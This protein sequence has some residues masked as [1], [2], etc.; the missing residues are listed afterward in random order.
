L[1][2]RNPYCNQFDERPL[3]RS[4]EVKL[5]GWFGI[6]FEAQVG[7][8]GGGSNVVTVQKGVSTDKTFFARDR[9]KPLIR[10]IDWDKAFRAR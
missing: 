10:I 5:K 4:A 9:G 8:A 1:F 2:G 6:A 3:E 7:L